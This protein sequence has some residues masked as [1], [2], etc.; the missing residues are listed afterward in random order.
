MA[1]CPPS[2]ADTPADAARYPDDS[3][4]WAGAPPFRADSAASYGRPCPF[5][6]VRKALADRCAEPIAARLHPLGRPPRNH[7]PPAPPALHC[8]PSPARQATRPGLASGRRK[9]PLAR[10]QSALAIASSINPLR[11]IRWPT[12]SRRMCSHSPLRTR[13]HHII[14]HHIIQQLSRAGTADG[15]NCTRHCFRP[16][17]FSTKPGSPLS[18]SIG[19][20]V[21]HPHAS[22]RPRTGGLLIVTVLQSN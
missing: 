3:G 9:Q 1:T 11:P 17:Q 22:Y 20:P 14:Q 2:A 21:R 16:P 12:V 18:P 6:L 19:C 7:A 13:H 10:K 15:S 4:N 5:D 8:R